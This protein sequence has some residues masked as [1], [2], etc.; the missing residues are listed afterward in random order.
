MD[1]SYRMESPDLFRLWTEHD[2]AD[3][4]PEF[5]TYRP[6]FY[7]GLRRED[8]PV[9]WRFIEE[10][11]LLKYRYLVRV[12][13][14]WMADGLWGIPFPGSVRMG[15]ALSPKY[16]GMPDR[17]AGRIQAWQANLDSREPGADPVEEDFDYEASDAEGLEI[18]REVKMF[19]GEDHYVEFRPFREIVVRDGAAVDLE[20]PRFITDIVR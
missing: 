4:G 19:L 9:V 11:Y 2:L 3:H 15:P 16:F 13:F 14:D 6:E 8:E 12:D 18:A 5:G 17:L 1:S 10:N 20:V 7:V